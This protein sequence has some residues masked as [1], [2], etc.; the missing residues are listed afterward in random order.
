MYF[1]FDMVLAHGSRLL[2]PSQPE[3]YAEAQQF[4]A[5]RLN[6]LQPKR[7]RASLKKRY[8]QLFMQD[9]V[10]IE[11]LLQSGQSQ[12]HIGRSLGC[13]QSTMSREISRSFWSLES[14]I[15]RTCDRIYG[16]N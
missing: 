11:K 10:E 3:F 16:T 8:Y 2:P 4:F 15:Q 13:E 5:N 14:S 1:P 12:A 9:L 6:Y 7:C